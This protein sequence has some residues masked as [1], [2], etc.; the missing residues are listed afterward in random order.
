MNNYIRHHSY[1]GNLATSLTCSLLN[2]CYCSIKFLNNDSLHAFCAINHKAFIIHKILPL[3]F[4]YT[5]A[6][7]IYS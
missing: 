5:L 1:S 2:K 3:M 4:Y 6:L 7:K